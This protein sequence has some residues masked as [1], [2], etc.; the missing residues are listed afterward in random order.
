VEHERKPLKKISHLSQNTSQNS[1]S[2]ISLSNFLTTPIGIKANFS[3]SRL[4]QELSMIRIVK[5]TKTKT[6]KKQKQLA[7]ESVTLQKQKQKQ[8][9]CMNQY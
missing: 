3:N 2:H 7:T 8:T 1:T 5:P 9:L 4:K 6:T